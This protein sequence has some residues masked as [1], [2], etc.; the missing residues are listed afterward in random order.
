MVSL[1]WHT[2]N[3]KKEK[4]ET[5]RGENS[6]K[7]TSLDY[8]HRGKVAERRV[9]VMADCLCVLLPLQS[10]HNSLRCGKLTPFLFMLH[11]E[12]GR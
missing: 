9:L 2:N 7:H 8:F 6:L 3:E 1:S 12:N 11:I 5:C 4:L 10:F